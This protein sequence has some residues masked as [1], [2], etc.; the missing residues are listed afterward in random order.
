LP[1]IEAPFIWNK[2][3]KFHSK[4]VWIDPNIC[5]ID[6][7]QSV[8]VLN[9]FGSIQSCSDRS[10]TLC[11]LLNHFGSIQS[12]SDRSKTFCWLLDHFGSIQR[13]LD[14]SRLLLFKQIIEPT[15]R[16]RPG[17]VRTPIEVILEPLE[18]SMSLLSNPIGLI[19]IAFVF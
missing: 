11:L 19:F 7:K 15:S 10:K 9:H 3:S 13:C 4:P 18:S 6:P 5:W 2:L 16:A 12:C 1:W 8:G 14:R 17:F